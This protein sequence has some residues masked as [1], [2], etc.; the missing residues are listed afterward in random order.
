MTSD[1]FNAAIRTLKATG[2][3]PDGRGWKT[4]LA[5]LLGVSRPALNNFIAVGTVSKQ[6]DLA[7]AALIAGL[8]PY[9]VVRLGARRIV[10][11]WR[12]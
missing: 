12:E 7:V 9:P 4:Q 3:L 10:A 8:E 1:E 2:A 5:D 11:D 6:T